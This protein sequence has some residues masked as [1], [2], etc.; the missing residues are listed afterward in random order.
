MKSYF[1][2]NTQAWRRSR[3]SPASRD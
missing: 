2:F 1:V 3:A